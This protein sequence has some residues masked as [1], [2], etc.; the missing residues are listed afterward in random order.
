MLKSH[1]A[2]PL[3]YVHPSRN[4]VTDMWGVCVCIDL[5]C[6]VCFS[7]AVTRAHGTNLIVRK[8]AVLS[9]K[10]IA[11]PH[12]DNKIRLQPPKYKKYEGENRYIYYNMWCVIHASW[13][14][15]SRLQQTTRL[16]RRCLERLCARWYRAT[17]EEGVLEGMI[18]AG[19]A[20][21]ST[22]AYR[23]RIPP[24][25]RNTALGTSRWGC[26]RE[27][28]TWKFTCFYVFAICFFCGE[29]SWHAENFECSLLV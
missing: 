2:P 24:L 4:A 5:R 19:L 18:S 14:V 7:S 25:I 10:R 8:V 12:L 20:E 13:Q 26:M 29:Q 15:M 28:C 21:P 27:S 6:F 17:A 22:H 3:A 1:S 23:A 16:E 11:A 9:D